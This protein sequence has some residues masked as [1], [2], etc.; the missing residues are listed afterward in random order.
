[1]EMVLRNRFRC[2][3]RTVHLF[4]SCCNSSSSD[5]RFCCITIS[6]AFRRLEK[7]QMRDQ[8]HLTNEPIGDSVLF[9]FFLCDK[10]QR[11]INVKVPIRFES[12]NER[13]YRFHILET[14]TDIVECK[15]TGGQ[16]LTCPKALAYLVRNSRTVVSGRR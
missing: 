11:G 3:I 5:F 8:F 12:C 14:I 2:G 4:V 9:P 15:K 1:M 16:I 6:A 13:F 10:V 7:T